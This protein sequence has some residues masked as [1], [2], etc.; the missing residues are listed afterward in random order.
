MEKKTEYFVYKF[1]KR[2]DLSQIINIIDQFIV[3]YGKHTG[4]VHGLSV[5]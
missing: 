2:Y 3:P 1:D 4:F 5:E